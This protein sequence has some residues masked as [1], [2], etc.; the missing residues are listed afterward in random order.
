MTTTDW[1]RGETLAADALDLAFGRCIDRAGDVMTG[2]FTLAMDPTKPLD[3]VTKQ[4]V[5][6]KFAVYT[7]PGVYAFNGR[8]GSV[9]LLSS[10]VTGVGGALVTG[11]T[12]S[13]PITL[14]ANP[15]APLQPVTLQYLQAN[16]PPAATLTPLMDGTAAVGVASSWA[17]ADHVHPTDINKLSISGGTMG[18]PITLAADPTAN[19]QP[20]TKQYVDTQLAG[21]GQFMGSWQVA[22][23]IPNITPPVPGIANGS[24]YICSTANASVGETPPGG[25]PITPSRP[26][27]YSGDTLI[28]SSSGNTYNYVAGSSLTKAQADTLYLAVAGGTMAGPLT[29][30]ADPTANLQAATKQYVDNHGAIMSNANPLVDGIAAPGTSPAASRG[31]HV[32]PSDP[33]KLSTSGGSMSGPLTLSADPASAL[34]PVT[35]QYFQNNVPKTMVTSGD[36]PPASPVTNALWWDSVGGQL[37]INFADANST[38]WVQANSG[39]GV[40]QYLP[41][42]GGALTGPLTLSANATGNLQPVTLQ[43]QNATLV[44]YATTSSVSAT[45]LPLAGGT[46]TGGLHFGSAAASSV[47][48]L[49]RHVDLYGSTFG[50]S[51]T[52]SQLNYNVPSGSSHV[53]YA[54]GTWLG[55]WNASALNTPLP[56]TTSSYIRSSAAR[57]ISYTSGSVSN[58]SF[59]CWDNSQGYA[60]GMFLG[61]SKNLYLGNM[62]ANGNYVGPWFGYFDPNGNFWSAAATTATTLHSTGA[63]Q[64]DGNGTVN[65]NFGTGGQIQ[66]GT[67]TYVNGVLF[68]AY[69]QVNDFSMSRSSPWRY[70][71]YM[72]NYYWAFNDQNGYLYWYANNSNVF[73]MDVSGNVW[74]NGLINSPIAYIRSTGIAYTNWASNRIAWYWNG[75]LLY[76]LVDG[77]IVNLSTSDGRLKNVIGSYQRGL[78]EL[79]QLN[80]ITFRFKGNDRPILGD[81]VDDEERK[82]IEDNPSVRDT[83]KVNVGIIAQDTE[84]FFP[85]MF[86]KPTKATIDGELVDDMRT[87]DGGPWLLWAC[88]NAIKELAERVE[89]LEARHA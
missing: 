67:H 13:G 50:F 76:G 39:L 86:D 25:I 81:G 73:N 15:S 88:V 1:I 51:I 7:Q 10:D 6:G 57:I 3:A 58:A 78:T 63:L 74:T 66:S 16:M 38:Q 40:G 79:K 30:N 70:Q 29:L 47:T 80:P 75:S 34:Q 44:G 68:V 83:E 19:M 85:E 55:T 42:T 54:A 89:A 45:Y 24:Y 4:Y 20:A 33:T 52:S 18:G 46:L 72:A 28:W 56:I 60:A 32:H 31:D 65:G 9:A 84:G 14:A 21:K 59:C 48:D 69:G 87:L 82:R 61:G 12:M 41:I 11:F 35:L 2:E 49:T 23:N 37:M 71:Q 22:A 17:R 43:Q 8:I 62:D 5:D 26:L 77:S 64:V 27:L 53:F 36:A